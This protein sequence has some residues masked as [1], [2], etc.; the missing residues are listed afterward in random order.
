METHKEK[1]NRIITKNNSLLNNILVIKII[2]EPAEGNLSCILFT[3][4]S[5]CGTQEH[6]NQSELCSMKLG[7]FDNI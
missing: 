5:S 3:V 4:I 6:F 2:Y 7:I 1:K